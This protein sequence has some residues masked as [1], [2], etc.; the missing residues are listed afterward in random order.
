MTDC[1]T[2]HGQHLQP[3]FHCT[4]SSTTID[5]ILASADLHPRTT[6]PQIMALRAGKHWRKNG[7]TLAGYLKRA[8]SICQSRKVIASLCHPLTNDIFTTP[9]T[10]TEAAAVFYEGLY[11]SDPIDHSAVDELL[12]HLPSDLH[13]P[14]LAQDYMTLLFALDTIQSGAA[15]SPSFSSLGPDGLP[16]EI[17]HLVFTHPMCGNIVSQIYNDSLSKGIFS[18]SWQSTC[19]CLLP[20]KDDLSSLKN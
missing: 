2:S 6:N 8:I 5:Y 7:E 17:L 1:I 15:R 16:Y 13:L 10:M 19:V 18:L 3:T 14:E 4:L 12:P 11:T 20:K 9:N